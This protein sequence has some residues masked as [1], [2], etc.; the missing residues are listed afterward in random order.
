MRPTLAVMCAVICSSNQTQQ[1]AA[2]D[3][4]DLPTAKVFIALDG[5]LWRAHWTDDGSKV[6]VSTWRKQ[7]DEKD[8]VSRRFKRVEIWHAH[9]GKRLASL[10]ELEIPNYPFYFF[11]SNGQRLVISQGFCLSSGEMEVWDARRP[12]L[13]RTIEVPQRYRPFE[14]IAVSPKGELIAELYHDVHGYG[15]RGK[16]A[17]G[18]ELYD[19]ASGKKLR[20]WR[21]EKG[22]PRTAVFTADG[23]SLLTRG[24]NDVIGLW[25][26]QTGKVIREAQASLGSSGEL[27]LSLDGK[28]LIIPCHKREALQVWS[29]PDL[30]PLAEIPNP[31]YMPVRVQFSPSSKRVLVAGYY[32]EDFTPTRKFDAGVIVWDLEKRQTLSHW[33]LPTFQCGFCGEEHLGVGHPGAIIRYPITANVGSKK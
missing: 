8:E 24:S 31:F 9:T 27:A 7:K 21:Q 16:Y 20:S 26:V 25:D 6:L 18:I 22:M 30:K 29:V 28:K 13:E 12:Y 2:D 4:S 15:P 17:G 14:C 3:P 5:V 1:C 19:S 23:R 32:R 33:N 11:S 10:G